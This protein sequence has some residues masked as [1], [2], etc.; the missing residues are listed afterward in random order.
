MLAT[1]MRAGHAFLETTG[2]QPFLDLP[3]RRCF[4]GRTFC[5]WQVDVRALGTIIWGRPLE[6]DVAAMIPFFEIGADP[7]FRGHASFVDG[8]GIEAIDALAFGKLLSYLAARHHAWTP[9]I[10][11]QAILHPG[12]L[13]GALVAGALT[14]THARH[15]YQ[16]FEDSA[17]AFSFCGVADL[18][19]DVDALRERVLG[20]PEIVRRVRLALRDNGVMG[21]NQLAKALGLAQR[22]LERR[23]EQ[24][25]TSV[26]KQRE[27]HVTHRVELLLEG[28]D[29][30]LDAIA[31][32]V[33]L[34]SASHLVS[35][36]R[37]T[38]GSTPG[39]WR[40]ARRG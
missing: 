38:H 40:A 32:E 12:G 18:E 39:R 30:D 35:H 34:S 31:A 37:A 36:F 16:C 17:A 21:T 6:D 11:R 2:P 33:G 13:V 20:T 22:T 23:L 27:A 28:T 14:V 3:A 9:Q 19:G 24:A 7:R 25:G 5:F 10:E 15:R 8:R 26:R 1:V 29:L 4:V